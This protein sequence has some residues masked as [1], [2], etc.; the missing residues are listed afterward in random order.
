MAQ[1]RNVN[2]YFDFINFVFHFIY[3]DSKIFEFQEKS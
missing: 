2:T 1:F 3:I